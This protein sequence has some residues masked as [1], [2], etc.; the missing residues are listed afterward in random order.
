[1]KK[2]NGVL[3]SVTE[4]D[5]NLYHNDNKEFWQGVTAVGREAFKAVNIKSII[6]PRQIEYLGE[7]A[8][9]N[10]KGLEFVNLKSVRVVADRAFSG[11]ENL[12]QVVMHEGL[13]SIGEG[14]FFG[15]KK[16]EELRIPSSVNVIRKGAFASSG[17]TWAILKDCNIKILDNCVFEKCYHLKMVMLPESL[18]VIRP[19]AF[20]DCKELNSLAI[21][22]GMIFDSVSKNAFKGCDKLDNVY[23]KKYPFDMAFK[24][25]DKETGN[26]IEEE[27][28]NQ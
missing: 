10:C 26:I 14:C 25:I 18:K 19:F 13:E 16:L 27:V 15:C 23:F 1:M 21:P 22:S 7:G 5:L 6:I 8:F 11:C 4:E 9:E 28:E 2:I 3:Y 17:L 12:S 24:N 20:A